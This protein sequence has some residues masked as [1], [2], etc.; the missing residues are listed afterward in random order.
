MQ[1]IRNINN[2]SALL[3]TIVIIGNFDGVHLGHKTLIKRAKEVAKIN[4]L[5]TLLIT[6]EPH[7]LK[8]FNR[9]QNFSHNKF[10]LTN[11]S[12]KLEIIKSY[13]SDFVAILP[14]NSNL[15]SIEANYFLEQILL[16]KF[17][18]KY[19]IV[20]Y[21]FIFGKNRLGNFNFLEKKSQE[22]GFG[23]EKIDAILVENNICSS[24]KIRQL[25]SLG[26]IELANKLLG[27]NFAVN[28]L[29]VKG[30]EMGQKIGFAT[31][32]IKANYHLIFPHFG[33]YQSIFHI[34]NNQNNVIKFA[35]ITNFGIRPTI[36][37][38][39]LG[40]NLQPIFETHIFNFNRNIYY[41]KVKIELIKFIRPEKKFASIGEL[42]AQI[43]E[44]IKNCV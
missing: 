33:V 29:V 35:S 18:M 6:F 20:G 12:R 10:Y 3:N 19:L 39:C 23:L 44:D 28:G 17:G 22:I 16:Q 2:N 8:F 5:K 25:I 31:A 36:E 32:N 15:S 13:N 41:Q 24:S 7:P 14:F 26:Q 30:K 43:K 27:Y 42:T 4:N 9:N 21:D 37:N 1:I 34:K 11:L 38:G 40:N